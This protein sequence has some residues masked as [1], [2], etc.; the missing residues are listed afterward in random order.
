MS[1]FRPGESVVHAWYA[2]AGSRVFTVVRNLSDG[3]VVCLDKDK[4]ERV[5]TGDELVLRVSGTLPSAP[6][7]RDRWLVWCPAGYRNRTVLHDSENE[8]R[9]VARSMAER[10]GGEFYAVRVGHG[11]RQGPAVKPPLEEV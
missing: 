1:V 2:S 9:K 8:A 5:L 3:S 10:H 6:C 11:Y 4:R 7:F